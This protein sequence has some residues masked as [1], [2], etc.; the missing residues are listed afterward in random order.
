M[1]VK[2]SG[3]DHAAYVAQNNGENS[4]ERGN[5]GIKD[6]MLC[7][8][9]VVHIWSPLPTGWIPMLLL[10]FKGSLFRQNLLKGVLNLDF[11]AVKINGHVSVIDTNEFALVLCNGFQHFESENNIVEV[12]KF[13]EN[14][15]FCKKATRLRYC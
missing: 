4:D 7:S 2:H 13:S 11:C 5:R 9:L 1:R 14:R 12:Y 6:R 15:R 8:A 10:L 3:K